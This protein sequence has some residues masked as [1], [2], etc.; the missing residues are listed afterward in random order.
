MARTYRN[1]PVPQ[2]TAQVVY[3]PDPAMQADLEQLN[4]SQLQ[5]RR[6]QQRA[7]YEIWQKR[8]ARIA[9]HD[10]KV[11]RF[12]LGFGSVFALALLLLAVFVGW[13]LWTAVGLGVLAIP[14]LFLATTVTAV[15]G[16]RCITIVQHWH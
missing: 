14:L 1:L 10:L 9:A 5:T 3:L 4:A 11:R 7:L 13:W 8:Q 2:Q 6:A 15:G 16:H 12:W